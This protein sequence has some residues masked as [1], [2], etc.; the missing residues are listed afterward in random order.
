MLL[1]KREG[2]DPVPGGNVGL[3]FLQD[4]ARPAL[5]RTTVNES[6]NSGRRLPTEKYVLPDGQFRDKAEFLMHKGNAKLARATRRLN[7]FRP[8]STRMSPSSRNSSREHPHQGGLPSPVLT[9][10]GVDLAG[11][12]IQ[13]DLADCIGSDKALADL[14]H[15][16]RLI[17]EIWK[18]GGGHV[19]FLIAYRLQPLPNLSRT[20]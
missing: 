19:Y 14:N 3:D 2:P 4:R 13:I 11:V 18:G 16:D 8:P 17:G 5:G 12:Y 15:T 6:W 9:N 1:R 7:S 10:D 20:D